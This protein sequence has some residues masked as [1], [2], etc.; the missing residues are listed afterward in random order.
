MGR[1]RR[2][3]IYGHW[4]RRAD[5]STQHNIIRELSHKTTAI[6]PVCDTH[7]SPVPESSLANRTAR[8]QQTA[9]KASHPKCAAVLANLSAFFLSALSAADSALRCAFRRATFSS[10]FFFRLR[11]QAKNPYGAHETQMRTLS[12]VNYSCLELGQID[13]GRKRRQRRQS[14]GLLHYNYSPHSSSSHAQVRRRQRT[15]LS[16]RSNPRPCQIVSPF[17]QAHHTARRMTTGVA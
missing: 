12:P 7:A 8:S 2:S 17:H 11:N 10:Y 4:H 15:V 9:N 6:E 3:I 13:F 1:R 16:Q 14:H 5:C